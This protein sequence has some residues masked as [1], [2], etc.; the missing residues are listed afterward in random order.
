VRRSRYHKANS[1]GFFWRFDEPRNP[2]DTISARNNGPTAPLRR[3]DLRVGE[4]ILKLLS[5]PAGRRPVA[6]EPL[7]HD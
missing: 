5:L 6:G 2:P 3:R 4:K 7:P 1:A